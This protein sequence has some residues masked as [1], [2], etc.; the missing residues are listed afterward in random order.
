MLVND[1][2]IFISLPRCASSS[3][4]L[5]CVRNGLTLNHANPDHDNQY[6]DLSLNNDDLLETITHAHERIIEL[7]MRFG[8]SYDVI[9][10]KRDKYDR[11]LSVWNFAVKI[12]KKYGN[13]VYET[14]RNLTIDEILFFDPNRLLKSEIKKTT[15]EFL[16]KYGFT[17]KVDDYFKNILF[18]VWEPL[19]TWHNHD[20][21]ILWFDF[22]KLNELEDW[23]SSKIGKPF[24]L[25]I[26]NS[27]R[28][29]K[30]E[31]K[32]DD[33]FIEKYDKIYSRFDSQKDKKTL[34]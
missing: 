31:L 9:A 8:D 5:T 22:N 30:S 16:E 19:S 32:I 15:N 28:D 18:I 33:H 29:I 14:M 1:K 7:K 12:S 13:D 26:S 2:F 3:F 6:Y 23:V 17:D 27:S 24:K 10:I 25:E 21:N 20:S 4:M 34:I 11:F